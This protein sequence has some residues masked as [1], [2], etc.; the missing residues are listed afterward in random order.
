M[1]KIPKI[2][3]QIW[4]GKHDPLP[5]H[6]R[7]MGE[8]W[9]EHHPDW[10]Y[11]F[12]DEERMNRFIHE[13]YPQYQDVYESFQYDVQRWD[14]IR[15]LILDKIGGMY[16]DFDI[17][18]LKPHDPL[19]EG[20]T[21]CFSAEPETHRIRFQKDVY[22]NNALMACIPW[23]P[24]IKSIINHVFSYNHPT[25][26]ITSG[27]HFLEIMNTTGPLALMDIYERY[28]D[29]SQ[30]FIIPAQQVSPYDVAE[31]RMI[32]RGYELEEFDNRLNNVYSL[33]Y[34]F[35]GWLL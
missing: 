29:K 25:Q 11:R 32:R 21:C 19:L 28:Y 7:M 35:G 3:H 20:N 6:F 14:A 33:H 1:Q 5:K 17:E 31:T 22:F 30:V 12:W 23:H 9:K 8:T 2:I 27:Q 4:S 26:S 18:C 15:Y 10:E 16:V 34:F 24:F 13:H